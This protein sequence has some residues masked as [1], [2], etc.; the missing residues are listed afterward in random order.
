MQLHPPLL[1]TV[2]NVACQSS[3]RS[4]YP[5]ISCTKAMRLVQHT[6]KRSS[7]SRWACRQHQ[8]ILACDVAPVALCVLASIC[9]HKQKPRLHTY[10]C[11]QLCLTYPFG[12]FHAQN[13]ESNSETN[14]ALV[15]NCLSACESD[16]RSHTVTGEDSVTH[17]TCP[18]SQYRAN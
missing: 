7:E 17:L 6:A 9:I 10:M 5:V 1:Q 8:F 4:K 3:V 16:K 15:R 13:T 2:A 12:K 18:I 14:F 11:L